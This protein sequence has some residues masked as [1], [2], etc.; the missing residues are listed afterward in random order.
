MNEQ[1]RL[2]ALLLRYEE[3]RAQGTTVSPEELCQD[4]PEL[5][6]E[7]KRQIRILES[8]NAV[9]G[10]EASEEAAAA[11]RAEAAGPRLS[12]PWSAE[13]LCTGSRYQVLRFH[14]KGGLG[15]VHVARDEEL[16]REVALKRLQTLHASNPNSRIRFLREAALTS[17]LEH[18]NIVP[19]HSMGHDADG[20]PF[21]AMRFIQGQTLQEAIEQFHAADRPGQAVGERHLGLRQLLSR[22]VAVCNAIDRLGRAVGERHL[23]LRQLL[24]RLVAVC[25][26][27]AYAHSKGIVHRDI[28]PANIMLGDF[29]ETLVLDWGLAKDV[30]AQE[31]ETA[32][33]PEATTAAETGAPM[34]TRSDSPT[35]TGV[36]MGTP[37]YMS[38]EQAE[39]RWD[40]VGPA[41]D[42]YSLGATLYTLL[43]GESPFQE[44]HGV[45]MLSKVQRGEFL[46]PRQRKRDT[47]RALEA[48]CLKAMARRPEERYSSRCRWPAIWS[49]GWRTNR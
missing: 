4:C 49:T 19:V 31:G 16:H 1:S 39:G 43:T 46:P 26:T 30:G 33:A 9:L 25:N 44:R 27:I 14:A 8:M 29:G 37:T 45:E 48:I 41:S 47:P 24:S 42:V 13:A 11:T 21:Y 18:P 38:P 3:L 10:G 35:Q 7:L 28:K 17:R 5:V 32:Q 36:V 12:E 23:G 15:E 6:E 34:R 20:C 40:L 22:L 2:D